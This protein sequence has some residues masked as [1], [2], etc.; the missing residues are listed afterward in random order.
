MLWLTNGFLNA[1]TGERHGNVSVISLSSHLFFYLKATEDVIYE[2]DTL[3]FHRPIKQ[4]VLPSSN[5]TA[6]REKLSKCENN[7]NNNSGVVVRGAVLNGH[8]SL[9]VTAKLP[10]LDK[11]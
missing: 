5:R 3:Y 1:A 8:R 4:N 9:P 11:S 6:K 2:V 7:N 10:V